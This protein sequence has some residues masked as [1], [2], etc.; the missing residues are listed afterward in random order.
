MPYIGKSNDGF[1]IR[2]RITYLAS[3]G[4]TTISGADVNA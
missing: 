4:A 1:G 2:E 3:G